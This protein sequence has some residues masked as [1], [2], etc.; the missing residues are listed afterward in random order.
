MHNVYK[1]RKTHD[2]YTSVMCFFSYQLVVR[3]VKTRHDY[4]LFGSGGNRE[5]PMKM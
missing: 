1:E 5:K 3:Y 4:A 2:T